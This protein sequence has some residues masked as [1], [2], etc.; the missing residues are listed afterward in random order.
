MAPSVLRAPSPD[1][2]WLWELGT[3]ISLGNL[4]QCLTIL[5]L[6]QF[7]AGMEDRFHQKMSLRYHEL[8]VPGVAHLILEQSWM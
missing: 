6:G 8:P 1:L 4:C 7:E 5:N 2:E 3:T